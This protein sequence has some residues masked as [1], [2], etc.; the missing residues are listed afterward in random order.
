MKSHR[1][2]RLLVGVTSL[3]LI[4]C[5]TFLTAQPSGGPYGP[6]QQVYDIP[7]TA[8]AVYYVSPDGKA[9]APGENLNNTTTIEAAIERV[10]T[11]DVIILRG[12]IYRT[13]NLI[14]NQGITMQPYKDEQ[15]VLKGTYVAEDWTNLENGL[16]ITK[17]T[18]LFPSKPQD[19]WRRHREGKKTP[20]HRF[21]NDMV[22]VDGKFLQ[23]AGWEGEVDENSYFIDYETGT[24]YIGI[25]PTDRL[26][27]ITAFNIALHRVTGEAH[28][29][30]S[31]GIGPVIKGITFTQYAYRAIEVEGTEPK[32]ISK[33]TEHGK[34]V[35]GTTFEHCTISYCSRVAAYL[36][37]DKLTIRHCKVSDTST[38]G[39]YII[40]SSDVLL[41]KNIFTR[42]NIERITG[43]YPAAVKIFNQSHRVTCNDNLV[44][45][46]PYSNGIWYD[47]GCVDG[48]FINNWIQ[49]VGNVDKKFNTNQLWP[50]DNGFFFEISKGAVCAGNVFVNCD[51][52]IFVLNSCNVKIYNNTFVNSTTSIGRNARSAQGDHFG[53]HP[54][55][56]ADVDK[57]D[58]HVFVNNLLTA[59]EN[60]KRPLL[61]VW[62]PPEI[63]DRVTN[64]QLKEFDH[65]VYVNRSDKS[66][67]PLIL[68]SPV[69]ND[70]CQLM[71]ESL[72]ELNKL[73]PQFLKNS[74]YL[75][76]YNGPLF[77]GP[78]LGNYTLLKGFPG[79]KTARE[80]P[81]EI[82]KY[83]NRE[84]KEKK[85]IGAFPNIE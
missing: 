22:F 64:P 40:A 83:I 1:Y 57:R 2:N 46:L 26:V 42:N 66:S 35:V 17:W 77:K 68:W 37:G 24:V 8:G 50:S 69:K 15:P 32:G 5:F 72:E 76:G 10:K 44:I 34:K 39:I 70:R 21:N 56:G 75:S 41:E 67:K 19:W 47:V 61:A 13:G 43:Y 3:I 62:Q 52:G 31:D 45:D 30:A 20:Q 53:W 25:D 60:Y 28:G 49:D 65:N 55:T 12:G 11:G 59:D 4:G 18:R 6:T 23:S 73:H 63:C 33:E 84:S 29:K 82:R 38:E 9:E 27:E 36:F 54:S 79:L 78:V 7:K 14:L 71:L 80:I 16:W 51:Q 74:L 58:G 48:V 81:D 85:Y